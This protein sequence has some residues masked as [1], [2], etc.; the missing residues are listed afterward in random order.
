MKKFL[1]G[2]FVSLLIAG[3]ASL[4]AA[5]TPKD[6]LIV[7]SRD[8][9]VTIDPHKQDTIPT[10]SKLAAIYERLVVFDHEGKMHNQLM[11]KYEMLDPLSW[12]IYLRKGVRFHN[13]EPFTS[14]AVKVTIEKYLSPDLKTPQYNPWKDNIDN[15]VIVNDHCL[16]IKTKK[17]VRPMLNWFVMLN[18]ISPRANKELGD[19]LAVKAIGTGPYRFVEYV[20]NDRLVVEANPDYWGDSP[21]LKRIIFR[22]IPEDSARLAA[23]EAGEI[24]MMTEV[25]PDHIQAIERNPNLQVSSTPCVRVLFARFRQNRKPFDDVKVRQAV[26]YALNKVALNEYLLRGTGAVARGPTH[27]LLMGFNDKLVPYSYDMAKAKKLLTEAGYP[28]GIDV[29]FS[30]T[31]GRYIKDKEIAEAMVGQLQEAGIRCKYTP[32]EMGSFAS[33]DLFGDTHDMYQMAFGGILWDPELPLS[34]FRNV[35]KYDNPTYREAIE[36][37]RTSQDPQE[38]ESAYKKAEEIMWDDAAMAWTLYLPQ[39]IAL[40]KKVM[41]FKPRPDELVIVNDC[42]KTE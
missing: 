38:Y 19:Q 12:K 8:A 21:K 34:F 9:P 1:L 26:N 23:L 15:I 20:P 35:M 40:H 2:L 17:K 30:S 28:N 16:V 31:Y 11:T 5:R 37:G 24:D 27:P 22:A 4:S 41:G 36:L 25:S 6:T 7:A 33:Q 39:I 10:W 32:L 14:E 42:W 18:I 3:I 13:G 29:T